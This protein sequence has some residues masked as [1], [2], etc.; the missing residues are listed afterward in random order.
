MIIRAN[1][2]IGIGTT[3]P[4]LGG[5]VNSRFT[6]TQTDN[7]TGFTVGNTSGVPRFALNGNSNG[8]W[9]LWDYG[10]GSTWTPGITQKSGNVGIGVSNPG[11][12]LD[13]SGYIAAGSLNGYVFT[14]DLDTGLTSPAANK[15]NLVT[16]GTT[17][18]HID[19]LGN[20]GIGTS[21]PSSSYK[22]DVAGNINSSGTITGNNI[23]AKYQDVAE[24]V[25]STEQLPAGTVVVLDKNKSNQVISSMLSYDTSVA[26]VISSQPGIVL[27]EADS[28]KVL[29]ATT[30]RVRVN[31]DASRAPIQIGD[32][33]VTSDLPGVAMKSEPIEI[34][35]RKIHMPGTLIGKALE[36]LAK[37]QGKILVLLSLQ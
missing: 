27:G 16:G 31:V 22:L 33:L 14:D 24:W 21:S 3:D 36:P 2:N 11:V 26:G 8:S 23:V 25:P 19:N 34:G 18:F 12:K 32:L 13:V 30:G 29:V 35:G 5:L 4:S 20:V 17:R 15:L 28:G 10:S 1:G 6:V 9:T 37:G 7:L